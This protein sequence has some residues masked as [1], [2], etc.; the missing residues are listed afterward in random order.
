MKDAIGVG[1]LGFGGVNQALVQLLARH[2]RNHEDVQF[3]IVGVSDLQW[4]SAYD[5]AGLSFEVLDKVC[6][7][8]GALKA[9]GPGG[10]AEPNNDAIIA[11]D[12]CDII[13]EATYSDMKNGQPALSLCEAALTAGKHVV[14]TNKGVVAFGGDRL[15]ALA[16]QRD[17]GFAYEGAVM[18]GTP[19]LCWART[20][21]QGAKIQ[22][23]R[24]VLNG[25]SNFILGQL[26]AGIGF[27]DALIQ[28]RKLG[29]A[30]AD[31]SSDVEGF[32]V[33]AKVIVLALAV[34]GE[35]L[36]KADISCDGISGFT[37][38]DCVRAKALNK[39]WK[40]MADIR[41]DVTGQIE[42]YVRPQLVAPD[43][44]FYNLHGPTNALEITTETLGP[45]MIFGPGAGR[46]ET[47]YALYADIL[48]LSQTG[49]ARA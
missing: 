37:P 2:N 25:T 8:R 43:D 47:A 19:L 12:G 31:S 35:K 5:P 20:A 21:L 10:A 15:S 4:G 16:D 42:A 14:T 28:A 26:E 44:P 13:A 48:R 34:L 36:G 18:S 11:L 27:E 24:G 41:R 7:T 32:D 30:E 1:L 6:Q 17:L 33:R 40:L 38:A 45:I 49:M 3:R 46:E 22:R 9:L 29:Y 23:I 39:R